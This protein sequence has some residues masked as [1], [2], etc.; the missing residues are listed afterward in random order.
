[1][2]PTRA[3]VGPRSGEIAPMKAQMFH[4]PLVFTARAML[5]GGLFL[6]PGHSSAAPSDSPEAFPVTIQVDA[7]KTKGTLHPAWRFFGADE[8][9]YAYM[10]D[11]RK[12]IGE[13]GRLRPG[14][15][16]FRTHNAGPGPRVGSR[17]PRASRVSLR[18]SAGPPRG[19]KVTA[20]LPILKPPAFIGGDPGGGP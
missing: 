8:P 18:P 4:T 5:V 3:E 15:V 20:F 10:K 12:L 19:P 17:P 2:R 6:A 11:G 9:K 7:S 1:M 13:P 16:Y 14:S